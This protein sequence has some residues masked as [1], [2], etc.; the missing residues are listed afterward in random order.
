VLSV[1]EG[2][3]LKLFVWAWGIIIENSSGC[4]HGNNNESFLQNIRERKMT[5]LILNTLNLVSRMQCA[6]HTNRKVGEMDVYLNEMS[7]LTRNWI[8][9]KISLSHFFYKTE[10]GQHRYLNLT[11]CQLSGRF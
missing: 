4:G 3:K 8:L 2:V 6:A 5:S 11:S 7:A 10:K 1:K 9:Y